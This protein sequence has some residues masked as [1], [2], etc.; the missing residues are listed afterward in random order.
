MRLL[1]MGTGPFAVPTF[2]WLLSSEHEIAALVTRPVSAPAGRRKGP[3][4]PMRDTA[5]AH[6]VAVLDPQDVNAAESRQQLAEL[7]A[8]LLVAC[9]Y[10][11]ILSAETLSILPKGGINLH[12][13]LLPEYRGAAPINWAILDGKQETGVTV[14]HMT[15]RLD[16]GPCLIQLRTRI[17]DEEEAVELEKRL[18]QLGV[19]AVRQ[20]LSMLAPWDG[21]SPIGVPQDRS[22]ATRAP[23]LKKDDGRVDWRRTADQIRNQVRALKPWPGTFTDWLRSDGTSMHLILDRV[24]VV[25]A[26]A[27]G[28][29]TPG[30]IVQVQKD[31]LLVAT[32]R[33]WLSIERIQPA[34]KRVMAIDEFLRGHPIQP[35]QILGSSQ[36]DSA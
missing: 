15:A 11:Q 28:D 27:P 3:A 12:A 2:Q 30:Q 23:R 4:N 13:S 20:A 35:G 1:M 33:Q 34:G 19:G 21:A 16:S 22:L 14:I 9:D 10:G 31:Q 17:G 5:E 8:D 7:A 6:G 26:D 29:A 32:G 25:E 18:A 36:A 24:R